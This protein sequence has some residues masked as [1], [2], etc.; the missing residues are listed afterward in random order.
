MTAI[1]ARTSSLGRRDGNS[2]GSPRLL[3]GSSISAVCLPRL[4]PRLLFRPRCALSRNR[5]L[6]QLHPGSETFAAPGGWR[7]KYELPSR[8]RKHLPTR[9]PNDL[10]LSSLHSIWAWDKL[11][12]PQN[13]RFP[14][15]LPLLRVV[16]LPGAP[17]CV[18]ACSKSY[19]PFKAHR[20]HHLLPG[21]FPEPPVAHAVFVFWNSARPIR[22]GICC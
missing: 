18:L 4:F 15:S 3:L 22:V 21:A 7:I 14:A 9:I 10:S 13:R 5:P 6:V 12:F 2:G 20:Q 16:P 1:V 8:A 19:L 11:H 17:S